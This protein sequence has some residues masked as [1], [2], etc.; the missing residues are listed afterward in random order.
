MLEPCM[1]YNKDAGIQVSQVIRLTRITFSFKDQ[2]CIC[3]LAEALKMGEHLLLF[4]ET[5]FPKGPFHFRIVLSSPETPLLSS[6]GLMPLCLLP[7]LTD[8]PEQCRPS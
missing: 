4:H 7:V 3:K 2:F 5:A 1:N 6:S 8:F